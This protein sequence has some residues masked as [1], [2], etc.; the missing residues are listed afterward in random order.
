MD[1]PPQP[2]D[3]QLEPKS[4]NY[5]QIAEQTFDQRLRND[6]PAKASDEITSQ[7]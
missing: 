1:F 6:L 5:G 2:K 4:V 7:K 3:W